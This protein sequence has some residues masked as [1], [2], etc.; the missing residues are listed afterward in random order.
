MIAW[1]GLSDYGFKREAGECAY[2]WCFAIL[3]NFLETGVVPEKFDVVTLKH[4]DDVEYGTQGD[5]FEGFGWMNASFLVGLGYLDESLRES[6]NAMVRPE[7]IF[8]K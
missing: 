6:L 5:Q 7:D 8:K 1:K 2:R 4:N 3:K